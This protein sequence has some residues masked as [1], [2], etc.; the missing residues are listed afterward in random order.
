MGHA[1]GSR[2]PVRQTEEFQHAGSVWPRQRWSWI[3]GTCSSTAAHKND[4]A[5]QIRGL[6]QRWD[7]SWQCWLPSRGSERHAIITLQ[8][9][10][11]IGYQV[12]VEMA[13]C[14]YFR[15]L[16]INQKQHQGCLC[17]AAYRLSY[18]LPVSACLSWQILFWV[19]ASRIGPLRN[20]SP[21]FLFGAARVSQGRLDTSSCDTTHMWL[22]GLLLSLASCRDNCDLF[23]SGLVSYI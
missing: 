18:R 3:H 16:I 15:E 19:P 8:W 17:A 9:R 11:S 10:F 14:L 13:Y 23:S 2:G 4:A 5:Q 1:L 21:A 20:P 22:A 7:H 12:C 6:Q